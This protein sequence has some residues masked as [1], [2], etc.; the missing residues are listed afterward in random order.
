[1]LYVRK[2]CEEVVG[3]TIN[4]APQLR[5]WDGLLLLLTTPFGPPPCR[6]VPV[7]AK[8]YVDTGRAIVENR[9]P[10]LLHSTSLPLCGHIILF[11]FHVDGCRELFLFRHLYYIASIRAAYEEAL[12]VPTPFTRDVRSPLLDLTIRETSQTSRIP[13]V[14]QVLFLCREV[15][16]SQL[17]PIHAPASVHTVGYYLVATCEVLDRLGR[18]LFSL[19][20]MPMHTAAAH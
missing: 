9:P 5:L 15:I 8:E 6:S 4:C 11:Q 16:Q 18:V 10:P 2:P 3:T 12:F 1:V 13:P 19:V 14:A 7:V 17:V 20:F